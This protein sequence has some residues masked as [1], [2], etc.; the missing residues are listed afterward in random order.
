[1]QHA[2]DRKSSQP[3][4]WIENT[5]ED[6]SPNNS[7]KINITSNV[8][9]VH[10]VYNWIWLAKNMNTCIYYQVFPLFENWRQN[11]Q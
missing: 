9:I 1:M 10:N 2:E 6:T 11:M 5:K 3:K 4:R 7:Q 8:R